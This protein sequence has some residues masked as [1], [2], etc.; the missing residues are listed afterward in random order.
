MEFTL[1]PPVLGSEE[2]GNQGS[3]TR[4]NNF[5]IAVSAPP[6]RPNSNLLRLDREGS[7]IIP[8]SGERNLGMAIQNGGCNQGEA[9]LDIHQTQDAYFIRFR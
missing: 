9:G 1:G 2:W 8:L 5:S 6:A 3:A 4:K 7:G